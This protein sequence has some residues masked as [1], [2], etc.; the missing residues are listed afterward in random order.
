MYKVLIVDDERVVRIGLQALI[1][2]EEEGYELVGTVADGMQAL[3]FIEENTVD[4][5][6]TDLL[7]L[8]LLR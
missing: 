1:K 6:I 3:C 5:I 2:W 8:Y 4:I 7:I